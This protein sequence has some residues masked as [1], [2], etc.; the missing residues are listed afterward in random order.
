[1]PGRQTGEPTLY[2]LCDA[3][4]RVRVLGR[5]VGHVVDAH[6]GQKG[7]LDMLGVIGHCKR[8]LPLAAFSPPWLESLHGRRLATG[9]QA[10]L[11]AVPDRTLVPG[12]PRYVALAVQ[13]ISTNGQ[14]EN[15]FISIFRGVRHGANPLRLKRLHRRMRSCTCA[16]LVAL[17]IGGC[18]A[19]KHEPPATTALAP[20]AATATP[21]ATPGPTH[22]TFVRDLDQT[23]RKSTS[24]LKAAAN[25]AGDDMDRLAPIVGSYALRGSRTLERQS[26]L[27]APPR[28][29]RAFRR[30]L[31][32]QRQLVGVYQRMAAALHDGD[33]DQT[34]FLISLVD[35]I[36]ADR[37]K[38]ALDIGLRHC[39]S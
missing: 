19:G 3:G 26:K 39:G 2:S 28:D 18:G 10:T 29:R 27:A 31:A 24:D 33:L 21:S 6:D 9:G 37:T 34:Q 12:Q 16:F 8:S 11:R 1:M 32:A 4:P 36:R 20:V 22:A 7:R 15:T 38:A 23:C 13:M 25:A 17:A 14:H 35:G 5:E 30:Y